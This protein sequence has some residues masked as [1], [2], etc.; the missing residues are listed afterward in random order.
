[1]R[2][3]LIVTALE[4]V[5]FSQVTDVSQS[6]ATALNQFGPVPVTSTVQTPTQQ[7]AC[8]MQRAGPDGVMIQV[9]NTVTVMVSSQVTN[10][11]I[12]QASNIRVATTNPIVYG[13][14]VSQE[15]PSQMTVDDYLARNCTSTP[16]TPTFTVSTAFQRTASISLSQTISHTTTVGVS[17]KAGF[18]G[19]GASGSL[20]FADGSAS[21]TV[22]ASGTS[23]T[24]TTTRTGSQAVPADTFLDIELQT[25][26]V[27]YTVPFNTTAIVDADLSANDKGYT[28][29]SDILDQAHRTF[30]VSGTIEANDASSGNLVF[31]DLPFQQSLCP[32][33]SNQTQ[34]LAHYRPATNTK[35]TVRE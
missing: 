12:L 34:G 30:P 21:A 31:Y 15:I 14:P 13:T 8:R 16:A 20:S 29:L 18:G 3:T 22:D 19:F 25:W 6:V 26:P 2:L 5:G 27:H 11:S 32:S 9:C 17:V 33:A 7:Q 1:L 24:V 23:T 35:L 4:G 28:L 10:S